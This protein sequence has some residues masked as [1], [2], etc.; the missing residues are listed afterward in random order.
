MNPPRLIEACR[1]LKRNAPGKAVR[2]F[3][4]WAAWY[5]RDARLCVIRDRGQIVA[6]ALARCL[7]RIEQAEEEYFHLE[8][9]PI[10][11]VQD[12]VSIHPLGL[13]LLIQ[14]AVQRFGPREAFAGHV[15]NRC[16]E[17]RMLPWK[18]VARLSSL[19]EDHHGISQHAG[20]AGRTGLR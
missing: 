12:I 3:V 6:I 5:W 8:S 19:A 16:G 4:R 7:E 14:H 1:F 10:V 13:G 17:L 15:F 9:G 11:W 20:A 2:G 18:S